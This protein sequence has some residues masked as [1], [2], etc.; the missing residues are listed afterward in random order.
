MANQSS[1]NRLL[2]IA[3]NA[4]AQR[5]GL[6]F[7]PVPGTPASDP[8]LPSHR[9]TFVTLT[10]GGKL[11]GCVGNLDPPGTLEESIATCAVAAATAD[12]RFSPLNRDE[13]SQ[14]HIEISLLT[15]PM[16]VAGPQDVTPGTHGIIVSQGEHRGLLLPQ[17]AAEHGWKAETLLS[18]AA[19]K[20]G[21]PADAWRSGA[22]IDVFTAEVFSEPSSK[23][24]G[25]EVR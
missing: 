14:V 8:D 19:V 23:T 25:G 13:L 5:L 7:S 24:P 21:L 4:I 6:P 12:P 15:P 1:R 11:R 18:Q 2:A 16:P 20:A 22:R 17:V 10:V 9:A 3:R